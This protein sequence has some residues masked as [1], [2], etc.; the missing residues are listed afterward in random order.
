VSPQERLAAAICDAGTGHYRDWSH[1]E[2]AAVMD[3]DHEGAAAA[4]LDADPHLAQDIADGQALRLLREAKPYGF[5]LTIEESY[6]DRGGWLVTAHE[7]E[8]VASAEQGEGTTI[9]E[10]A[11]ACRKA[12]EARS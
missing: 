5:F 9:A 2:A 12:L 8:G 6:H 10:A 11:D 1:D 7:P 3:P 4:I